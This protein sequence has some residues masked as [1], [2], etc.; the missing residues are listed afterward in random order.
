M[1]GESLAG[2]GE[3]TPEKKLTTG[4]KVKTRTL[5]SWFSSISLSTIVVAW[6]RMLKPVWKTNKQ[7]NDLSRQLDMA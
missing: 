7:K 6:F 5:I 2:M 3:A 4:N 1:V